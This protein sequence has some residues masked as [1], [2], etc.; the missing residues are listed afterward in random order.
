MSV[1]SSDKVRISPTKARAK[2]PVVV[3]NSRQPLKPQQESADGYEVEQIIKSSKLAMIQNVASRD[4]LN[5]SVQSI[6]N[7]FFPEM[8][9]DRKP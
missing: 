5:F 6:N 3:C 7:V 8:A 4:P 1:R 2:E 9:P